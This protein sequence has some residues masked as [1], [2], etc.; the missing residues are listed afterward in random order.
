MKILLFG[1]NGQIGW[2]LNRSLLPLGEIVALGRA[3][4]DFSN[5]ENLRAVVRRIKPDVIV[6]AVAYT[7]VDKAEEEEELA[8]IIN[9]EAPKV[10][11]EEAKKLNAI[12]VHYSTDYVFN[13]EKGT[14]YTEE[15]I[16]DPVNIYGVTKLVGEKTIQSSEADYLILRT[17]WVYSARGRNFLQSILKLAA[18]ENELHVVSD[19]LGTPNWARLLAD[20][21][22]HIIRQSHSEKLTSCFES[23][24]FH[25]TSSGETS[26]HGFASKI[27]EYIR[28]Y[29]F[30]GVYKVSHINPVATKDRLSLA[31]RPV[32]TLMDGSKLKRRYNIYLPK[33]SDALGCCM[34]DIS[35]M[36]YRK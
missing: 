17:S 18:D 27:V 32:N 9:G 29:K 35:L 3:D 6:N 5:P 7:A 11:A 28:S 1:K 4:A 33:W 20:A 12:L 13:G 31:R 8:I 24:L 36:C 22:A 15:D 34:K 26:W 10:L 30:D 23:G 14:P 21:S 25:L 19:Q 2:E 16:P